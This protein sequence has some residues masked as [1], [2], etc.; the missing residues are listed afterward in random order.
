[1]SLFDL[2]KS[3]EDK[4]KKDEYSLID[5]LLCLDSFQEEKLKKDEYD[6]TS[7]SEEE[8]EEDDYYY[9]DED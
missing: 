3:D 5:D 2:F 9:D 8:L 6:I 7:F 1:M 4:N